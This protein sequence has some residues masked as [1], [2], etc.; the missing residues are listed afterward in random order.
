MQAKVKSSLGRTPRRVHLFIW[1][2]CTFK[3]LMTLDT[4]KFLVCVCRGIQILLI[5]FDLIKAIATKHA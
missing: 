2:I 5:T 4:V 3:I 1:R